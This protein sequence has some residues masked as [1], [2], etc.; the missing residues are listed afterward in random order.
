[1]LKL[2]QENIEEDIREYWNGVRELTTTEQ[3]VELMEIEK[4]H[5]KRT[6]KIDEKLKQIPQLNRTNTSKEQFLERLNRFTSEKAVKKQEEKIKVFIKTRILPKIKEEKMTYSE[7]EDDPQ[8][9]KPIVLENHVAMALKNLHYLKA[10]GK[11]KIEKVEPQRKFEFTRRKKRHKIENKTRI[12]TM[13]SRKTTGKRKQR[14]RSNNE[15]R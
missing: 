11:E 2:Q 5:R 9:D 1:M 6:E 8:V 13:A 7:N 12:E 3:A 10:E 15:T 14:K 4:E